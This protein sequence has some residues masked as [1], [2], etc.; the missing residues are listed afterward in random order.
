MTQ[1][2]KATGE[3]EQFSEDKVARSIQRA[4]IPLSLQPKVLEHVKQKIYEGIPTYE[5]YQHITEFLGSSEHPY[6]KSKY[7][8]KQAIMDLGPTGYPFEDYISSILRARGYETDVRQYLIGTCV[9]HEIDVIARKEN[10]HIMVEAKFHN[11]PGTRSDV[12]VALYTKARFD[13][14]KSRHELQEAWLVTN[15]KATLDAIAYANCVG[16]KVVSWSYP[17]NESL[18]DII[19]EHNLHPVTILSS[20]THEQKLALLENHVV[21]CK[22]LAENMHLLDTFHLPNDVRERLEE[23]VAFI[24]KP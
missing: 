13:D 14:V 20:L 21:M 19:E 8:L 23:E 6:T 3:Q 4:G 24:T 22:D 11:N 15:T 18:R 7:G 12:Q 2:L 5:I 10:K 9:S 1:V 17:V 16:M